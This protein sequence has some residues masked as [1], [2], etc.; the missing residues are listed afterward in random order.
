ML[1][2]LAFE[3]VA[4]MGYLTRVTGYRDVVIWLTIY[5]IVKRDNSR[6]QTVW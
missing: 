6:N 5:A 4:K 1:Y 3:R 2:Q